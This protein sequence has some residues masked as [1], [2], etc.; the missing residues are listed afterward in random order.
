M[1]LKWLD[2]AGRING[3]SYF[4]WG[5]V[6]S[7]IK[8]V[9]DRQILQSIRTNIG[10]DTFYMFSPISLYLE[11]TKEGKH[12]S[13]LFLLGSLTIVSIFFGTILTV[14]RLRDA[15]LSPWLVVL[16]FVPVVNLLFFVSLA[17]L[18]SAEIP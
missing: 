18:A 16:F 4:T 9:L 6:L 8:W 11:L 7:G 14:K 12:N 5:V 10:F 1:I 2:P 13:E 17:A 15:G 3:K